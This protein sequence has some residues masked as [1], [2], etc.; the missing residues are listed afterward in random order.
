M[1][2]LILLELKVISLRH[3]YRARPACTSCSLTRFYTV[4]WPTLNSHRGISKNVRWIILFKKFSRL[5]VNVVFIMEHSL[6][7]P[8]KGITCLKYFIKLKVSLKL[9]VSLN[10]YV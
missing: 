10:V 4:G 5:R 3:L 9:L 7:L 1:L 2:T 8:L 6:S